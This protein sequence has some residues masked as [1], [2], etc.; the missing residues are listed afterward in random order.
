VKRRELVCAWKVGLLQRRTAAT[1][2]WAAGCSHECGF[3]FG[4]RLLPVAARLRSRALE[5]LNL[6]SLC[7]WCLPAI[8]YALLAILFAESLRQN[9]RVATSPLD[10]AAGGGGA[11]PD[12]SVTAEQVERQ[13]AAGAKRARAALVHA[14]LAANMH[15]SSEHASGNFVTYGCVPQRSLLPFRPVHT[16]RR[17]APSAAE[18]IRPPATLS[19]ASAAVA[20]GPV[21]FDS[22]RAIFFSLTTASTAHASRARHLLPRPCVCLFVRKGAASHEQGPGNVRRPSRSVRG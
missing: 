6:A 4:W 10:G 22:P 2:P 19:S 12:R 20:A 1:A 5:S 8:C 13:R 17:A 3:G 18:S 11:P 21:G 7:R 9:A 15:A 16:R 14:A